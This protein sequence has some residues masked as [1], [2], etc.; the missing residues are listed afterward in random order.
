M[1]RLDELIEKLCPNGVKYRSFGES[2]I[3]VRGASPRPIKNILQ[4]TLQVRIGLK[5]VM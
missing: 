4:Q 1:S 2:A 5:L 3:I